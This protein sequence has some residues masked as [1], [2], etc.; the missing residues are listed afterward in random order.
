MSRNRAVDMVAGSEKSKCGRGQD[1]EQGGG[2]LC[3]QDFRQQNKGT[4][5]KT[6]QEYFKQQHCASRQDT[7]YFHV[8]ELS[9]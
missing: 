4:K 1:E 8:L 5:P 6:R 2:G 3:K 9:R 7:T